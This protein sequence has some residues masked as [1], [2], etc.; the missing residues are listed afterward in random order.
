MQSMRPAT[1][2]HNL[3]AALANGL[4]PTATILA[5]HS[6]KSIA[7]GKV[8]ISHSLDEGA[9]RKRIEKSTAEL[10]S[11]AGA[12]ALV[13][14]ELI[15]KPHLAASK[16]W[17][18]SHLMQEHSLSNTAVKLALAS[19]LDL[20]AVTYR[21]KYVRISRWLRTGTSGPVENAAKVDRWI[22]RITAGVIRS[23][24]RQ[25]GPEKAQ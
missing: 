8:M 9:L 10:A 5:R 21:D 7:E 3:S 11:E 23:K 16:H 6:A 19:L 4:M 13:V 15:E 14:D 22:G 1:I 17:L 2:L 18:R 25:R 20:G 12:R 24:R